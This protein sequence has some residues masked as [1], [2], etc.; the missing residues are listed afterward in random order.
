MSLVFRRGFGALLLAL[1]LSQA[2]M[3]AAQTARERVLNLNDIA[4]TSVRAQINALP[5]LPGRPFSAIEPSAEGERAQA[6]EPR[7][8]RSRL[9]EVDASY[10]N[11]M[12]EATPLRLND[13]GELAGFPRQ[14][15]LNLF[16]DL[17]VRIVNLS[18]TRNELGLTVWQGGVVGDEVGSATIII[19]GGEITARIVANGREITIF[20]S[21]N[22][23]HKI[24]EVGSDT[25]HEDDSRPTPPLTPEEMGPP[26][27]DVRERASADPTYTMRILVAYTPKAATDIPNMSAAISLAMADIN[28]TFTNS[29]IS[30][31]AQLVGLERVN[32]TEGTS[33]DDKI[34]D[35]ASA[36]IG[37]FTRINQMRAVVQADMVAVIASYDTTSSCGL[38]FINSTLDAANGS[39]TSRLSSAVSLTNSGGSCLP[40]TFTHEVGHNMGAHHDRFVV[41]DDVPGP[42]GYNYGY[43]DTTNKFQ[44]V[45]AYDDECDSLSISC[46]SIQYYS[47][48]NVTYQGKTVGVA[49]SDPK[50]ANNS[51][52]IRDA[53]PN[54][55][56]LRTFLTLPTTPMLAVFVSGS[57]TVSSSASGVNNCGSISGTCAA[58]FT[59]N[60]QVTLTPVA[61][62]GYQFTGWSGACTGTGA[63]TVAMS[64]SRSVQATFSPSL[65][66]ATVYSSAQAGAQSFLRFANT[67]SA[68]STVRVA[69]ADASSGASL[70]T[71]TSPSIA[72]GAA[73]QVPITTVETALASGTTK[74]QFFAAAVQSDMTGYIQHVLYRP[75]DGTLTNLSTCD[76]GVSANAAQVANVHSTILDFG[77]PS[78]IAITNSGTTAGTATLGIYDSTNGTR[79]GTYTSASIAANAQAIVTV[80]A[81]QSQAG[82]TPTSTMYHYTIKIENSFSGS[83]QHLV[84]NISVGVTTDMTTL[85]AFGT[86]TPP[87]SKVAVRQ[88][89]PI[90]SSAQ[91]GSQ[92][93]LRF[94]NTGTTAGTV[95]VALANSTTGASLGN[96]T[97]PSIP[98]GSS[99]Q[100]PI[101]TVETALSS[102]VTKPAYYATTLLTQISGYFQHVLYR[103][104]DGTLTNLSTCDVGVSSSPS[105]LINVHSSILDFG[106]PSSVVVSNPGTTAI[107]ATLGIFDARDGNRIGTYTTASIAAGARLILP[108]TTIQNAIGYTPASDVYH[109]VIK[110]EGTFTGFLQHLVSNSNVGVTTDMTTMCQLPALAASYTTCFPTSCNATVGTPVVGQLKRGGGYENFRYT[111][112]AGQTYTIDVKGSSSNNGTLAKPYI[113]VLQGSGSSVKDGGGGGTGT[114]AR[115]TF[116]P[117]TTGTYTVQITAYIYENNAGTFT[118]TVN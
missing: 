97:S 96:W 55:V 91:S 47:N 74:P 46:V 69:L 81:I 64:A 39:L 9:V 95:N 44:D 94:F 67:G 60:P 33:D 82:I 78:S 34:L 53:M 62:S 4:R 52:K 116:T 14:Q 101:T 65:R 5:E 13:A 76:S 12:L 19:G 2:H 109:Y 73:L 79:L 23:L 85:C 87:L 110:A 56:R 27:N 38:G 59:G 113:Y 40:G 41:T 58:L 61:L 93:F 75:A 83:L 108:I 100:Y 114:D 30:A 50:A 90:F 111:L 26:R 84:N 11:R 18:I 28:A 36:G 66:L 3:A 104:A 49:D 29:A 57:G 24:R 25:D 42:A 48:P 106:F 103:P 72:A 99:A 112:T 86:V 88:P 54:I 10:L 89:G 6:A 70:G 35:D 17:D 15:V 118:L 21:G 102:G 20:P 43:V 1:V 7:V 77:F 45:M 8:K 80:A 32:Y 63:C 92:S 115:I 68:A 105:Q 31:Q 16:D 107:T 98:A 22:G 37:D 117:A 51:R 71:W